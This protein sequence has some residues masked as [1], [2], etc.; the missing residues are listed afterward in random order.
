MSVRIYGHIRLLFIFALLESCRTHCTPLQKHILILRQNQGTLTPE[1]FS[2]FIDIEQSVPIEPFAEIVTT[3][4]PPPVSTS[5]T[6]A[7]GKAIP[8]EVPKKL[9]YSDPVY[10]YT[11]LGVCIPLGIAYIYIS[12]RR[13]MRSIMY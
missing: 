3:P 10:N 12:V 5:T 4:R 7:M 2:D 9:Q 1:L 6:P 11:L 13:T 8:T